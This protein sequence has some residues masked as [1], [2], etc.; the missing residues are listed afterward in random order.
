MEKQINQIYDDF[1]NHNYNIKNIKNNILPNKVDAKNLLIYYVNYV[2]YQN[3]NDTYFQEL[4]DFV[5]IPKNTLVIITLDDF[6]NIIK[7]IKY[8]ITNKIIEIKQNLCEEN[9][10]N[11]CEENL[12]NININLIKENNQLK[13]IINNKNKHYNIL[14]N[15][16]NKIK[17]IIQ[18]DDKLKK[19]IIFKTIDK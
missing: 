17:R 2:W 6:I 11:L 19:R 16:Y 10:K 7:Y 1:L 4:I 14:L 5:A 9:D 15:N 18:Q 8:N 3:I 12:K 13:N